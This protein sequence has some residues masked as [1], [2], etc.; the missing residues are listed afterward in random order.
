MKKAVVFGNQPMY[1]L[2]P[3]DMYDEN[4]SHICEFSPEF[5]SRYLDFLDEMDSIQYILKKTLKDS[6][7]I[8]REDRLD[9][10]DK[11]HT[12]R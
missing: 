6:Q 1:W 7:D 12:T 5:I 11:Y 4:A 9:W 10:L 8:F 2:E 3:I